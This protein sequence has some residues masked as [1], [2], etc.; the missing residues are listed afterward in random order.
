M[1]ADHAH[2][3]NGLNTDPKKNPDK[4]IT[5]MFS[6]GTEKMIDLLLSEFNYNTPSRYRWGMMTQNG[7]VNSDWEQDDQDDS[8]EF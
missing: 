2:T 5:D 3:L 8:L 1:C 7:N 4:R 6:A